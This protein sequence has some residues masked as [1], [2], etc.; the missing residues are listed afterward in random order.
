MIFKKQLEKIRFLL[1]F[2]SL[3]KGVVKVTDFG[4]S[5]FVENTASAQHVT[6]SNVG[7]LKWMVKNDN[8]SVVLILFIHR[9]LNLFWIRSGVKKRMFG[10]LAC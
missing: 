3:C 10:L 7:P 6:K 2:F 8:N 5:R 9:R 1:V 4:M